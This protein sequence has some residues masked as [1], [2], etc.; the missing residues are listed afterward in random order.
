M[1]SSCRTESELR[2]A[3]MDGFRR[4]GLACTPGPV[5]V[6]YVPYYVLETREGQAQWAGAA[7][8]SL[9]AAELLSIP[10]L[11]TDTQWFD[12]ADLPAGARVL[13]ASLPLEAV[14]GRRKVV[15]LRHVPIAHIAFEDDGEPGSLWLD[16][17]RGRIL[18]GGPRPAPGGAL[19]REVVFSLWGAAGASCL[20][21]LV[22]PNPWSILCAAG[23]VAALILLP[24][25]G[26]LRGK[27]R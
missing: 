7:A 12:P 17:D 20:F 8:A 4:G 23:A 25:R 21:G 5:S 11:G 27:L 24:A 14:A 1:A 2:R 18:A 13:E 26:R 6:F 15:E 10:I 9:P 3:A 19:P 16:A 22:L